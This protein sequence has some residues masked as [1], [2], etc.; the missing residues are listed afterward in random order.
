MLVDQNKNKGNFIF[1]Q[2][3][4]GIF[5]LFVLWTGVQLQ[6]AVQVEAATG[7]PEIISYQGRLYDSSGNL[8]G[9]AGTNY[10]FRFSIWDSS[11]GG[12]KLWPSATPSIMTIQ[13]RYGVFNA[14]IGDTSAGGDALT[15]DFNDDA[16]YL[17]IE[18]AS[19]ADFSDGEVLSPR[20]RITSAGYAKNA[21]TVDGFHASTT[22]TANQIVALNSSGNLQFGVSAPA[23]QATGGLTLQTTVSGDINLTPAGQVKIISATTTQLTIGYDSSNYFDIKV[24]PAGGVTFD[25]VGSSPEFIVGDNFTV[26]GQLFVSGTATSTIAGDVNFDS[27]T[28]YVDSINNRVGIGTVSPDYLVHLQS[29]APDIA[30]QASDTDII[31][32]DNIATLIFRGTDSGAY[33]NKIGA[34]IKAQGAGT[35]DGSLQYSAP[36]ELQFFTQDNSSVNRLS[37]PRMVIT[38]EGRVGIGVNNPTHYFEVFD[39]RSLGGVKIFTGGQ[40][41]KIWNSNNNITIGDGDG[42]G[43]GVIL[44][45]DDLNN[46]F[47]FQSG[48]VGI[49]TTTPQY[50]LTVAGDMMLAGPLYDNNYSAGSNGDFLQSTAS[51]IQWTSSISP[52]SL[53]LT[54]GYVYRGNSSNQAEAT[55]TIY[56]A[57]SGNIGIGT[58]TPSVPLEVVSSGA[59]QAKFTSTGTDADIAIN[60]VNHASALVLQHN[61]S[62]R[63]AVYVAQ[64]AG[65]FGAA[66]NTVQF[67][68]Y[69][70]GARSSM[71]ITQEGRIGISTTTPWAQLSVEGQGTGPSL[72]VSDST[73]NT[74]FIVDASGNVGI[75]TASPG[76]DLSFGNTGEQ[77][78]FYDA[79]YDVSMGYDGSNMVYAVGAINRDF[80]FQSGNFGSG[81]I[82]R[83]TGTG[84]LGIATTTPGGT[85]GE[86]LTVAGSGY[87]TGNLYADGTLINSD[88]RIAVLNSTTTNVD[89][90]TVNTSI[91]LP[92]GSINAN[93]I[94]LP[95]TNILVGNN[96]GYAQATSSLVVL[97]NGNVGI[98]TTAP[99]RILQVEGYPG[100]YTNT[101]GNFVHDFGGNYYIIR[102]SGGG[103]GLS[104]YTNTG[105]VGGNT[106]GARISGVAGGLLFSGDGGSNDHLAI[107]MTGNIGIGTTTPRTLLTVGSSTPSSIA[108]ANYYNSAYVSGDLEV[109]GTLYADGNLTIAGTLNP[110]F[111]QGSVVFQGA[112]GL[113]Q[114][115]ANFYWDDANNRL[116]IGTNTPAYSLDVSG[117]VRMNQARLVAGAATEIY[118]DGVATANIY[119]AGANQSLYLNTN[120]GP[121]YIGAGGSGSQHL[122]ITSSGNIGIATTTPQYKLTVA[123]DAM[124]T[125]ALY[126]NNYSAGLNGY[127]LQSTGS[128]IQWVAT[129]TLGLG[130]GGTSE[131]T[132]MGNYLMP[133]DGISEYIDVAYIN[134]SSTNATSTFSGGL[135]V[136][137][138]NLVVDRNSGYV[139][140]GTST[141]A[142]KLTVYDG[143]I[144]QNP[145]NPTLVGGISFAVSVNDL[146]ISGKYLY[147]GY[148]TRIYIYDISVPSSP[149]YVGFISAGTND[150]VVSGQYLYSVKSYS[151]TEDEF[152]IIDIS[153]ASAPVKIGGF[154]LGS[155]VSLEGFNSIYVSG[156]YAYLVGSFGAYDEFMIFDISDPANPLLVG[157]YDIGS[158]GYD[159]YVKGKYAYLAT[160][161]TAADLQIFDIS[162][163][164][165]PLRISTFDGT[166]SSYGTQVYVR[167]K[168][169][170][171]LNGGFF[172]II[173]ISDPS[174]P[175]SKSSLSIG[176]TRFAVQGNYAFIINGS[177][178]DLF[179][180]N[181]TDP[182][183]P[184][185]V[186]EVLN[187]G[188]TNNDIVIS[189]KYA[190]IALNSGATYE[191]Q[192]FDIGGIDTYAAN[193]GNLEAD[194]FNVTGNAIVNNTLFIQNAVNI[195][196]GGILSQGQGSFTI[197]SSTNL[198]NLYAIS[199]NIIDS[200][201]ASVVDVAN[202]VHMA[203]T[204]SANNIGTGLLF[205]SEDNSGAVTSTARIASIFTNVAT[206]SP[207]SALA[208]Y[209]KN[210]STD[211]IE[212]LRIDS[213]GNIGIATTTPQYKLTVAGDAMLTGALYDNNYSAGLNGYVL[214][215]TGSGIQ[216][217]ATS[218]LGLGGGGGTSEWTDMGNYLMPADGISEYIDVAYIN[219]SSTNATSTFA[220]GLVVDT[221]TLVVD[222]QTNKVGIGTS[223]P[224]AA[225]DVQVSSG[226]ALRAQGNEIKFYSTSGEQ[227]FAFGMGGGLNDAYL[228]MYN[229]AVTRTVEINTDG[230]SY[231][232]GG[233]LG[234]G[235]TTPSALLSLQGTAGIDM[236]QIT[237]STGATALLFNT[238]NQ[239]RVYDLAG[240]DY[241]QLAH[242]GTNASITASTGNV[243]IGTSGNDVI[244]GAVGSASNL[245]FEESS[246][247]SGQGGNTITL[248]V[249]GDT[250][251]MG[252]SGVT[253]K[254]K[255]LTATGTDLTFN[256]N[257]SATTT[258]VFQNQYGDEKTSLAVEGAISAGAATTT[259]YNRFGLGTP[260]QAAIATADDV[261]ITGDLEVDGTAYLAGGTAWTQGDFAEEMSIYELT[262]ESGE[263]VVI[264][265]EFTHPE[266]GN[267]FMGRLSYQGNANNILGVIST[268]PAGILKY[269]QFGEYGKPIAL[270]GTVPV[271]VT[272]ENGPIRRGD[273]LT[274]SDTIPGVAMKATSPEAG[275]LGI[276]LE[277]YEGEGVGYVQILLSINNKVPSPLDSNNSSLVFNSYSS[278][279]DD[280]ESSSIDNSTSISTSS[281]INIIDESDYGEVTVE[282]APQEEFGNVK[283][284]GEAEFAGRVRVVEIEVDTRIIVKGDIIV[285]GDLDLSGAITTWMWDGSVLADSSDD[286]EL[287]DAVAVIGDNLV[288]TMWANDPGFRPAVGIAVAIK[289]FDSLSTDELASMPSALWSLVQNGQTDKVR[290]VKVAIGGVVKGY[291]DLSAGNRY[292]LALNS[293]ISRDKLVNDNSLSQLLQETDNLLNAAA[294]LSGNS[295]AEEASK[296]SRTLTDK[297]PEEEGAYIQVIGIAKSSAELLIQP[298]L[299]YAQWKEGYIDWRFDGRYQPLISNNTSN[300]SQINDGNNN[301]SSTS[302]TTDSGITNG[303]N[304]E[305][306]VVDDLIIDSY[307][308]S[309]STSTSTSTQDQLQSEDN[310]NQSAEETANNQEEELI[311]SDNSSQGED[312]NSNTSAEQ[313]DASLPSNDSSNT[314]SLFEVNTEQTETNQIDNG[315]SVLQPAGGE[316]QGIE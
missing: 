119:H 312:I 310:N 223:T 231:F 205:S 272:T 299:N 291:Q 290:M 67:L 253:Y 248:G 278:G 268:A 166:G 165:N 114:D 61:S 295:T 147:F 158:S 265:D 82:M 140:I 148:G 159:I 156:K 275:T 112:S 137:S 66:T 189:G 103:R 129:S 173:D 9:G 65:V 81:E 224:Q 11:T 146:Y 150:F 252:V 192:V 264:N 285:A 234:V 29:F 28:L 73:N 256:V 227:R 77:I 69:P 212:R 88:A 222:Y 27:G 280:T 78:K 240:T 283:V 172:E 237:T 132:D 109:D 230:N 63:F 47:T 197:A 90:L 53:S 8:L 233:N 311:I 307:T 49:A 100:F 184:Y 182:T 89:S 16:Y 95:H 33:T 244:I 164:T 245:V 160:D 86:K 178:D 115:N 250:I 51:G 217:V 23:I 163:P 208:F 58:S 270:T 72:V 242:D 204:S 50:K 141:P 199:G 121:I 134:A 300:D 188:D 122:N 195:G 84:N 130:D 124:L 162:D 101:Q 149:S 12:T 56:I 216:W 305:N 133:A 238:Q 274:T 247:I 4:G 145:G 263:V 39:E 169:A 36:T 155:I 143:T 80:V 37:L 96:S 120:S 111:I 123:G 177:G 229:D 52:S 171:Y 228:Y 60:S 18:V 62:N 46:K 144:G 281:P 44:T 3:V 76:A 102:N 104:I 215:S 116:G 276:A 183:N 68:T 314:S 168:Y 313:S 232:N 193:I 289:L 142:Y 99:S 135:T 210:S 15:L 26:Q 315:L 179:V 7:V 34:M 226:D 220:G 254:V 43:N 17:Q 214:Q 64:I 85:Y 94:A 209:T 5:L 213:S 293:K 292:F 267:L 110:Q 57:D 266:T 202:L 298:S 30:M 10:Y 55:S 180:Y 1:L 235:T 249:N 74:D 225:L 2:L 236:L 296:I 302:T 92:D 297:Q 170:Y 35:W 187:M 262:A 288:R 126:D 308:T 113:T 206:T 186:G 243:E 316:L 198:S 6:G 154:D 25:A 294:D 93:D 128:G 108:S 91:S 241:I 194:Y 176:A 139:G 287:G 191:V 48:N 87:F 136:G 260:G 309:T 167:G 196:P 303:S 203:Y 277:D 42:G 97:D 32:N 207:A 98:G 258:V 151:S 152:E 14:N 106:A 70:S 45:V 211:L 284:L 125:G 13:V 31:D 246:T 54:H 185:K 174:S 239:L 301:G 161:V 259:A 118:F 221:N 190:Y 41:I 75:G 138:T 127:V 21:D 306:D 22:P 200:N 271:K 157:S 261:F 282:I 83:L 107:D 269:G 218:T 24:S 117:T 304:D 20:Q 251:D 71:V 19:Q 105:S 286:I 201:T 175:V 38:S 279:V 219:A 79:T 255:T 273:L 40:P 131:W 59:W 153:N 257:N 181:I